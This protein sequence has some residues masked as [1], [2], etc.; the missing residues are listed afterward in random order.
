MTNPLVTVLIT[1]YNSKYLDEAMQS[2]K[3]QNYSP[4]ELLL[5]DDGS[6]KLPINS[7]SNVISDNQRYIFMEH[8]GLP[9]GLI[10]GINEAKGKYVAILDHDDILTQDSISKRV[11]ALENNS[12]AAIAYGDV[13]FINSSG[14]KYGVNNFKSY[15]DNNKFIRDLL[16]NPIAP[17][18]HTAIMFKKEFVMGVGN[19]NSNLKSYFDFDLILRLAKKYSLVHVNEP[20]VKY[21]TDGNNASGFMSYRLGI[22]K[23]KFDVVDNYLKSDLN[24]VDY[25]ARI[26]FWAALK[27]I[28][29]LIA[30]HRPNFIMSK[31]K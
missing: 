8:K 2:V 6:D 27:S 29:S 28:Y 10:K 30:C 22:L 24:N 25:K 23:E 15:T 13:I 16:L 14:K 4:I 19:Y 1:S 11:E 26:F 9:H 5:V 31:L 7:I 3:C 17:I 18:Q 12:D 21:R 20:V